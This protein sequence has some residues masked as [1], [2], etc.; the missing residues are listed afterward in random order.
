MAASGIPVEALVT[1]LPV[2]RVVGVSRKSLRLALRLSSNTGSLRPKNLEGTRTHY[3]VR[4][5][6]CLLA[7]TGRHGARGL[8]PR[9]PLIEQGSSSLHMLQC[10]LPISNL[11]GWGVIF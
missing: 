9:R 1:G 4:G 11:W 6:P 8:G 3:L 5:R 2:E 7:G 10:K